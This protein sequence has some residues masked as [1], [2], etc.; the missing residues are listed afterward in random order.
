M[1]DTPLPPHM[2]A[3]G[4]QT[5]LAGYHAGAKV[6]DECGMG[7]AL[8]HP[9]F[10]HAAFKNASGPSLNALIAARY[11]TRAMLDGVGERIMERLE[12]LEMDQTSLAAASG[13]SVQRLNNYIKG[14][15]T[16]DLPTIVRLASALRTT[17]DWLLGAEDTLIEAGS[18]VWGEILGLAGHPQP[19]AEVM[20]AAAIEALRLLSV[21]PSE[22]PVHLR[23]RM[24]A[25]TAWHSRQ[26]LRPS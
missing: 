4:A 17:T 12:S 10:L 24:A 7:M 18:A 23:S 15:R 6:V 19:E 22:D 13:I 3:L 26:R 20:I 14:R 21:L 1:R 16:P 8:P 5:E 9:S 11:Y 25:Q 2:K